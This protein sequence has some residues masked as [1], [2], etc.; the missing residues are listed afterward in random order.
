M[1]LPSKLLSFW[2]FP[3]LKKEMML[4]IQ[5]LITMIITCDELV[6]LQIPANSFSQPWLKCRKKNAAFYSERMMFENTKG[7]LSRPLRFRC[8]FYGFPMILASEM[9]ACPSVRLGLQ[10][11]RFR[12]RF[13]LVLRQLIRVIRL[14]FFLC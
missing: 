6:A 8:Q 5:M 12:F 4:A 10:R 11:V 14:R 9:P 1:I 3:S 13:V 7:T 2:L